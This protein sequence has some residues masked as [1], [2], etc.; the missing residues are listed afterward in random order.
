[1]QVT[2]QIDAIRSLAANPVKK[3]VVPRLLARDRDPAI[4]TLLADAIGL[5]GGLVIGVTQLGVEGSFFYNS[6][7]E[8]VTGRM[9]S[10][11][12]LKQPSSY[13]IS[14]HCMLQRAPTRRWCRWSWPRHDQSSRPAAISVLSRTSS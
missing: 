12:S 8:V 11:A 7:C 9:S 5:F 6:V 14:D 4:L 1:M 2:D 13:L 3:L 10:Q